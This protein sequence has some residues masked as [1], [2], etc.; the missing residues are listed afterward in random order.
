VLIS[1]THVPSNVHG[2]KVW[3]IGGRVRV[4]G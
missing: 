2:A 3:E 4:R 1:T